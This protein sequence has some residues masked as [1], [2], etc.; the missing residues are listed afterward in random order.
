M[1]CCRTSR[2]SNRNDA[3]VRR[4]SHLLLAGLLVAPRSLVPATIVVQDPCTLIDAITAANTD[5]VAGSCPA[6]SGADTLV[7]T[8]DVTLTVVHSG[9][10]GLPEA[11]RLEGKRQRILNDGLQ[12]IV[13]RD[14]VTQRLRDALAQN[15][16]APGMDDESRRS[17]YARLVGAT[18]DDIRTDYQN[19]T[20]AARLSGEAVA[21]LDRGLDDLG[22]LFLDRSD[23]L[24]L[25]RQTRRPWII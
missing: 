3:T 1:T 6:G 22:H 9:E 24:Y 25:Q 10:T 14:A 17:D 7:L 4:A 13:I 16:A 20:G 2:L 12:S 15:E 11:V 19:R 21:R 18:I 23:G 8:A 5:M